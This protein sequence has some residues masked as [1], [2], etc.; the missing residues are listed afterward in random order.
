M[1]HNRVMTGV[2]WTVLHPLS[3]QNLRRIFDIRDRL[4]PSERVSDAQLRTLPNGASN[5][6]PAKPFF[7]A[8]PE[9]A[10]VGARWGTLYRGMPLKA[11]GR[12]CSWPA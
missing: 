2:I 8:N 1:I 10:R 9:P 4:R 5:A 11:L 3:M 6:L 7:D 12:E